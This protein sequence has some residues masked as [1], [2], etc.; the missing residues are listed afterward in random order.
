MGRY[1]MR[2]KRTPSRNIKKPGRELVILFNKPFR[3]LS[4]FT[5]SEG[6]S[7]LADYIP[8]KD[9]YAA[10]RLDFDSEGL[11]VL[12]NSGRLQH[13]IT[14]PKGKL[15]KTYIVQVEGAPDEAA[16]EKLR[17]GV[18]LNDGMTRPA[19]ARLIEEPPFIWP[20]V[21]PIRF[22]KS[23]PTAWVEITIAEGRN[24]QVRR[25]TAAVGLPA[26]RL[27]RVSIG[28]WVLGGLKP[29]EWKEAAPLKD[30]R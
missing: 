14:D 16:L 8:H 21:P 23:V 30:T 27:I 9:V 19:R 26:L 29:G 18:L 28:P 17:R 2:S 1:P 20:R 6:R 11:V 22:R 3:V 24:R 25:M 7:T 5:D 12:T 10:G 13:I 4:Q 15:P